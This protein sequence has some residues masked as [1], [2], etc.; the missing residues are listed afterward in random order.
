MT[1]DTLA[2][3]IWKQWHPWILWWKI[4]PEQLKRQTRDYAKLDLSQSA[5]G[6]AF[7]L[8]MLHAAV[9]LARGGMDFPGIVGNETANYYAGL[10]EATAFLMLGCLVYWGYRLANLAMMAFYTLDRVT[11]HV[12][13][14]SRPYYQHHVV[15][16]V[17]V[18]L[19][20]WTICMHAY[21]FAYRVEKQWT[22]NRP[23]FR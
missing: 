15:L 3:Q 11:G 8:A 18:G 7:L 9:V 1:G 21:Y 6:I 22:D 23:S 16:C 19:L 4:E 2:G 14:Y 17:C 5:R 20:G 13:N 10:A 12:V